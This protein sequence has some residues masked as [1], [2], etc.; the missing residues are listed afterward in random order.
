MKHFMRKLPAANVVAAGGTSTFQVPLGP[1]YRSYEL[2]PTIAG[3]G[4][5]EAQMAAQISKVRMLINGIARIDVSAANLIKDCHNY[6]GYT[7]DDGVLPILLSRPYARTMVG[8]ENLCI[9]TA[10]VD[11]LTIEVDLIVGATIDGLSLQSVYT[12]ESRDLG[13]MI[14]ILTNTVTTAAA[15]QVEVSSLP[16]SNGHLIAMHFNGAIVTA[17]DVELD[18]V[19]HFD[20]DLVT[21]AAVQKRTGRVPQASTNHIEATFLDRFDDVWPLQNVQDFRVKMTASGAGSVEIVT[22]TLFVPIVS[23]AA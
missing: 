6:Y 22:E 17:L 21:L 20:A 3:V 18:S 16:R 5:T 23:K 14:Q 7:I 12:P 2:R 13:A 15:G 9:G 19:N 11:T 4:A 1:T 10:N 8:E